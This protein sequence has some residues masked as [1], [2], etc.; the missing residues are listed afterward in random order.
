MSESSPDLNDRT[1]LE[2]YVNH[3]DQDAFRRLVD[4]Y[5]GLVHGV[6]LRR[7][8][9]QDWADEITQSVFT[10]LGRKA[11]SLINVR[12]LAGWLHRAASLQSMQMARDHSTRLRYHSMYKDQLSS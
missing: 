3:G 4:R 8:G 10:A 12:S 1:L 11:P 9:R 7:T 2:S 6:G 5:S